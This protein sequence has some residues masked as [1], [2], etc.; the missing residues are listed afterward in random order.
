MRN[1]WKSLL[2]SAVVA[3]LASS[4]LAQPVPPPPPS[5]ALVK[6]R[7]A[8]N[9]L[10]AARAARADAMRK[11]AERIRG[12]HITSETYVK[13]FVAE[14]D[15]IK[16]SMTAFLLGCREAGKPKYM[17]DG[18]C[19]VTLE[20]PLETII[21]ELKKWRNE[22]YKGN[23]F[24]V[25][26]FE[27]MTV[28]NDVKIL[29]ETGQGAPREEPELIRTTPGSTEVS[30]RMSPAA[31]EFWKT[32]CTP[33]GR[34]MAERAARVDG[35]RR[36]AERIKG[37]V[38]TSDTT[39]QD[40]VAQSDEINVDMR[41]FLVGAR[42]VGVR[43]HNDE[44]I[45]EVE[46]EVT[47]QSVFV[48]LKKWADVHYKGDKARLTTYEEAMMTVQN[49][50]IKE[51]GTGV[52]PEQ[53][54]NNPPP[55]VTAAMTMAGQVPPWATETIKATGQSALDDKSENPAQAKLM[56]FRA[57]ELDAR[58]KLAEQIN[59][60]MINSSTSVRDFVA[61][62]DQIETRMLAFQQGGK[63]VDGSQKLLPDGTAEAT[64]EIELKPLWD[65]IV[66]W[67][68]QVTVQGTR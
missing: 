8:Q 42:E 60:L 39:V 1:L 5:D 54:L 55:Q 2:A 34:L 15:Q 53:Y 30:S 32:Y 20:V 26:D 50:I 4:L 21:V 48:E 63:V 65:M 67:R 49:T 38:I 57:A 66:S 16:T 19:E 22:Y 47:L 61:E 68:G 28:T 59:G 25:E 24:K 7:E 35:M 46:M 58:R 56:A 45:V 18:T 40:F 17:E 12:L 62:S 43:Y 37:V 10:L 41:T 27:K 11:L 33:R 3:C 13:D 52:P 6:Q 36:L 9:K 64:V 23:K 31:R 14:S 29:Q 44:L 51:T